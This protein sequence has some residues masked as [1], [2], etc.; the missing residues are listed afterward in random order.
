LH[1]LGGVPRGESLRCGLGGAL[2]LLKARYD[3]GAS[4]RTAVLDADAS[5][6]DTNPTGGRLGGAL[7]SGFILGLLPLH[8]LLDLLLGNLLGSRQTPP[9]GRHLG[10]G[11]LGLPNGLCSPATPIRCSSRRFLHGAPLLRSRRSLLIL[12]S[13]ALGVPRLWGLLSI[14]PTRLDH[15]I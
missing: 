8:L 4:T 1:G 9:V 15:V 12:G 6:I 2:V 13:C 11:G 3:R 14:L 10:P 5:G 7:G